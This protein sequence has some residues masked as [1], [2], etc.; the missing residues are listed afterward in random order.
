ML[1]EETANLLVTRREGLYLD[2]T[3]GGGGHL[4]EIAGILEKGATLIGIDR[5]PE[6]VAATRKTLRQAPQK[7]EIVNSTFARIDE[8]MKAL[9]ITVADGILLDLGLSSHQIDTPERGF[10]FMSDGPLD[11]R[12]GLNNRLTAEDIIN[13]YSEKKLESIFREYGEER[14]SK[15]AA[16]VICT[17]RKKERITTTTRLTEILTPLLP[18]RDRI[19][20]LSR[21]FQA[22]RIAVNSELNQLKETL[23]RALEYLAINGRLVVISYH[24]LE[25]RIV[26]RFLKDK[27]R[28]CTCPKEFP[29]CVCGGKPTVRLLTRKIVRPS[30]EEIAANSRARSA[31]LRAAEKIA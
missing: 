4:K 31:R 15:K 7:V 3:C 25:D 5:D 23:P 18:P 11:M 1:V 10:S 2:L 27:A 8:V 19:A 17:S 20:S 13:E 26:K 28:G 21:F 16:S 6:A 30:R 9:D 14:R 12:M 22:V 29:V 24:S